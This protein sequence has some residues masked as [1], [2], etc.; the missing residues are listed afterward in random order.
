MNRSRIDGFVYF[1][2]G[3]A[4]LLLLAWGRPVPAGL[5]QTDFKIVYYA[6]KAVLH[7]QDPYIRT[8]LYDLYRSDP[9][10]QNESSKMPW[11]V[12]TTCMY[13]PTGVIAMVPLGLLP[14][15]AARL[16][17]ELLN[18]GGFLF[19][20]Y[21][22]WDAAAE[23][24]PRIA[25]IL[26]LLVLSGSAMALKVGNS[27]AI[28]IG[29]CAIAVWCF[30]RNRY[31][32][33]GVL[34]M[35]AALALKPQN[36]GFI[37]LYFLL[38]SPVYRRHALKA[39]GVVAVF[40]VVSLLWI[41]QVS[42]HWATELHNNVQ[43]TFGPG[44]MNSPDSPLI[45]PGVNG[46]IIVSLQTLT[47]LFWPDV[48]IYGPAAYLVLAPLLLIWIWWVLRRSQAGGAPWIEL[49]AILPITI[50]FGYHRQYDVGLLMIAVP[51][52][53][54]LSCHAPRIGRLA[55]GFTFAAA[56]LANDLILH[57]IGNFSLSLRTNHSGFGRTLIY[58]VIGR[59]VPWAMLAMAVF[60]A[61]VLWRREP[62]ATEP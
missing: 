35:A 13:L 29:L 27:G 17:W 38:A 24:S 54:L 12:I 30:V 57:D 21:L 3:A 36:A 7:H 42:P 4:A 32:A 43:A 16:L 26:M 14:W 49:A 41:R 39:L 44:Q 53:A 11:N 2:L 31:I 50:L 37:W 28:V 40:G 51:T 59:P 20:A 25:G 52:C 9:A 5:D 34:C 19:A 10:H 55:V 58:A 62:M 8:T 56:L 23:W 18:A 22:M 15:H 33:A 46:P 1:L 60:H 6:S 61:W 48:R 47:S 45:D